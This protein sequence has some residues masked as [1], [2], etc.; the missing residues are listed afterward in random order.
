MTVL[1][2]QEDIAGLLLKLLVKEFLNLRSST[3]DIW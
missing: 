1:S 3:A 2:R